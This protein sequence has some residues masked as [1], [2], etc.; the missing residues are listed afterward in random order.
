MEINS[1]L[2]IPINPVNSMV[3]GGL[4]T[5]WTGVYKGVVKSMIC[6]KIQL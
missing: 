6:P 5:G 3:D 2:K 1:Q 4:S